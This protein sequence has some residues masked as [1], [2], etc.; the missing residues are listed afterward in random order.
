MTRLFHFLIGLL[1]AFILAPIVVVVVA[2]F[3][4]RTVP[5]KTHVAAESRVGYTYRQG[6]L[7]NHRP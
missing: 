2:S 4:A 1:A 7:P 3:S 6:L 5:S